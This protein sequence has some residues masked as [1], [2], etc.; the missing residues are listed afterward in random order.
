MT[1]YGRGPGMALEGRFDPFNR[2]RPDDRF[3]RIFLIAAQSGGGRLTER[4][5]AIQPRRREWVKVPQSCRLESATLFILPP[6]YGGAG[7]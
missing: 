7:F 6:D 4:T 3:R 5:A 2:G 1:I